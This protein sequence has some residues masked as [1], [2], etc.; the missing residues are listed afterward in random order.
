[1]A[2]ESIGNKVGGPEDR[3]IS[4]KF[5]QAVTS[6]IFDGE[7]WATDAYNFSVQASTSSVWYKNTTRVGSV[8][9][10]ELSITFS[11]IA[12]LSVEEKY[13]VTRQVRD[14]VI[15]TV[16]GWWVSGVASSMPSDV[17]RYFCL[18]YIPALSSAFI[19]CNVR[20][21][22]F[23]YN[24]DGSSEYY[25]NPYHPDAPRFTTDLPGYTG[26]Q[27]Y[28]TGDF[29]PL[30]G[31]TLPLRTIDTANLCSLY[32]VPEEQEFYAEALYVKP[33]I[34]N[35]EVTHSI[36]TIDG[37]I[38]GY[39]GAKTAVT[40]DVAKRAKRKVSSDEL[41]FL[42][43]IWVSLVET[44]TYSALQTGSAD[45]PAICS[46]TICN[47][48]YSVSATYCYRLTSSGADE[49]YLDI[50]R[51]SPVAGL[52]AWVD[53][54][55]EAN[56]FGTPLTALNSLRQQALTSITDETKTLPYGLLYLPATRLNGISSLVERES[57]FSEYTVEVEGLLHTYRIATGSLV[58]GYTAYVEEQVLFN[59]AAI[60]TTEGLPYL[61]AHYYA[62]VS[63]YPLYGVSSSG[64]VY[65]LCSYSKFKGLGSNSM[66]GGSSYI[67]YAAVLY[68]GLHFDEDTQVSELGLRSDAVVRMLPSY[69]Q[70]QYAYRLADGMYTRYNADY[71]KVLYVNHTTTVYGVSSLTTT[72]YLQQAYGSSARAFSSVATIGGNASAP[73]LR[74][75][76]GEDLE[77]GVRNGVWQSQSYL[78]SYASYSFSGGMPATR[79][80]HLVTLFNKP[81]QL[82]QGTGSVVSS[83]APGSTWVDYYAVN[84]SNYSTVNAGGSVGYDVS[85]VY[86][87][88][89]VSGGQVTVG[90][91]THS[92]GTWNNGENSIPLTNPITKAA[93]SSTPTVTDS[94]FGRTSTVGRRYREGE[95]FAIGDGGIFG[96]YRGNIQVNGDTAL[97]YVGAPVAA[98]NVPASVS[99]SFIVHDVAVFGVSSSRIHLSVSVGNVYTP[100]QSRRTFYINVL[101]DRTVV[102]TQSVQASSSYYVVTIQGTPSTEV[103]VIV[104]LPNRAGN[105]CIVDVYVVDTLGSSGVKY[106]NV[107]RKEVHLPPA[108]YSAGAWDSLSGVGGYFANN[109]Y[110]EDR[111]FT[112]SAAFNNTAL[113]YPRI[114]FGVPTLGGIYEETGEDTQTVLVRYSALSGASG[115]CVILQPEAFDTIYQEY[116][117]IAD[118]YITYA[119]VVD[120]LQY[121]SVIAVEEYESP[122]LGDF[123]I[124][125][126]QALSDNTP[127]IIKDGSSAFSMDLLYSECIQKYMSS[128]YVL[129]NDFATPEMI[130][131]TSSVSGALAFLPVSGTIASKQPPLVKVIN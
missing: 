14:G 39:Y 128:V 113:L 8:Y 58:D 55:I 126:K 99:D 16:K 74:T 103:P 27:V 82:L 23:N 105:A 2:Q 49:S 79:A 72:I 120:R 9:T 60:S 69:E 4:A 78:Y 109:S 93:A 22:L 48:T 15:P 67:A 51:Y 17:Y 32:F 102:Q 95:Y 114:G 101:V 44:P 19:H 40:V 116:L 24:H 76:Q 57:G 118:T 11:S 112:E 65:T 13:N 108:T 35:E 33:E 26:P 41:R 121:L 29:A 81:I 71:P 127:S 30:V 91:I 31:L 52:L 96:A 68:N 77:T 111:S 123:Y 73:V 59:T 84:S 86:K 119:E 66:Y 88:L 80:D 53:D 83:Q 125:V 46:I 130:F 34:D 89:T 5:G 115:Y 54:Y 104:S 85:I 50:D 21:A 20:D 92:K 56:P 124:N 97:T 1:M 117:H 75:L 42:I 61:L 98:L 36:A 122:P 63:G 100:S 70:T 129:R 47:S 106:S 64:I 90:T 6:F 131:I 110:G 45:L 12:G 18:S 62:T 87:V 107:C 10:G 25:G 38:F 43:P 37:D 94:S 3:V 7:G 28:G